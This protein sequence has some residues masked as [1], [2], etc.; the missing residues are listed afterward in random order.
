M[1]PRPARVSRVSTFRRYLLSDLWRHSAAQVLLVPP[2][3]GTV[4]LLP[5]DVGS[6]GAWSLLAT[7]LLGAYGL[8]GPIFLLMTRWAFR[9][10]RGPELRA[11]LRRT[12]L[13]LGWTRWFLVGGPRLWAMTTVVVGLAAVLSLNLSDFY[14]GSQAFV[15]GCG[16][17]CVVGTWVLLLVIYAVE[18]MRL[19]A[20]GDAFGF[21]SSDDELGLTDFLYL[22]AQVSTTFAGSDV[23]VQSSP[24]RALVTTHALVAFAYSTVII[25]V[26]ASALV[27]GGG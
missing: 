21:P 6:P 22:S 18:Y 8:Y 7:V 9:G 10:L 23:A 17:V 16:I 13:P 1:A 4:L 24:A 14:G 26:L 2:V 15:V 11:Q 27:S 12:Q 19:W 3:V 20:D 25:A 5:L